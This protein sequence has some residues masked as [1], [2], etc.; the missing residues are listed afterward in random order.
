MFQ[1][2]TSIYCKIIHK[3]KCLKNIQMIDDFEVFPQLNMLKLFLKPLEIFG[4]NLK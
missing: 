2:S 3:Q 4:I 1:A